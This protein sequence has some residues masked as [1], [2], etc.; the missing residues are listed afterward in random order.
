[1]VI[2]VP[3]L[4]AWGAVLTAILAGGVYLIQMVLSYRNFTH[5]PIQQ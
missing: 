4:G 2:F 3:L 5:Q 1:M